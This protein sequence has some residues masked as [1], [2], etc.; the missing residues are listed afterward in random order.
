MQFAI[1][2]GAAPAGAIK[3]THKAI[4]NRYKK[5]SLGVLYGLT[6]RGAAI[7][8][9]CTEAEADALIDQHRTLFPTY[10]RWSRNWIQA[11]YERGYVR[12]RLDWGCE[13]PADSRHRTWQNWPVQSTGADIMRLTTIYLDQM[14]VQLLGI[15]HDG[16]LVTCRRDQVGA[17]RAAI[18]QAC[19]VAVGQA[20]GDFPLRWDIDEH[21][22]RYYD[23]DGAPLWNML[24]T[25]LGKLYPSR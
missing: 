7:Q 17:C 18:D 8:I 14:N 21:Y 5:I 16:F 20:L 2:A 3:R 9:G 11:A 23:E 24:M 6:A 25:A 15:V 1:M 19:R 22:R 12:T 10:W 13:V 4:R